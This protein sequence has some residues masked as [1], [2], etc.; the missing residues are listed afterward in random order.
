MDAGARKGNSNLKWIKTI[1]LWL[2]EDLYKFVKLGKGVHD[3]TL[4]IICMTLSYLC[5]VNFFFINMYF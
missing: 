3:C 2:V 4:C 5:Q 1:Q